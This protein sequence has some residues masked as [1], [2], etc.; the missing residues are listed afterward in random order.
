MVGGKP[1]SSYYLLM[2]NDAEATPGMLTEILPIYK[3]KQENS[4]HGTHDR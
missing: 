3:K 2:N 4:H 1:T